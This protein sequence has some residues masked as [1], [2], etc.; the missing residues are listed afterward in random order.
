MID[1]TMPRHGFL[2]GDNKGPWTTDQLTKALT[3]ETGTRLGF[4]MTV[5]EYR[6]IATAIDRRFIRQRDAEPDDDLEEDE[7]DNIHDLMAAHSSKLANARY[8]RMGGLTRSLTPESIS[9]FR[10]ISDKWQTWYKLEIRRKKQSGVGSETVET[11]E[12]NHATG[13]ITSALQKMYGQGGKFK[14]EHQ[15]DAVF[16]IANG[17]N[18]L[19]IILPTEE[20]KSLTFMLPAMMLTA[21]TTL[22]I[23]PLVALAEDML[24]RCKT[25]DIDAIIYGRGPP[26]MSTIVIIV[27]ESAVTSTCMQFIV[28]ILGLS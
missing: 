22:V 6:H 18:Q 5:Q 24:K 28:D 8:A 25:A 10:T 20:G 13:Y 19:F 11:S 23:T 9:I 7:D 21:K 27:T 16:G 14:T 17:I 26:R 2:F 12:E 1:A 3:R 15:R 4:R